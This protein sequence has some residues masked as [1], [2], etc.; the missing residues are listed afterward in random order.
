MRS[1]A[2]F[3]QHRRLLS[4]R[5]QGALLAEMLVAMLLG[6]VVM[7][8]ASRLLVTLRA[9]HI[10]HE[11][12][13]RLEEEGARALGRIEKDLRRAGFCA[14]GC[15]MPLPRVDAFPGEAGASCVIIYYDLNADGRLDTAGGSGESFG[16]RL[17]AGALETQRAV[18]AC[19]GTQWEK[20]TDERSVTVTSFRVEG[21]AGFYVLRLG[22]RL[23]GSNQTA[24]LVR[25]VLAENLQ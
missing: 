15:D 21:R 2:A 18:T 10:A 5:Q 3:T 22:L 8:A 24:A 4:R 23:N 1:G 14:S 20:I 16:Y 9:G 25:L 11:Q 12:R 17:R 7:L 19:G 6:S 13:V